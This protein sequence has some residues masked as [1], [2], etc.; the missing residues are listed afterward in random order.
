MLYRTITYLLRS[1]SWADAIEP[2]LTL[3]ANLE[4][5]SLCDMTIDLPQWQDRQYQYFYSVVFLFISFCSVTRH[6]SVVTSS[7]SSYRWGHLRG[8]G[9]REKHN[10]LIQGNSGYIWTNVQG[11]RD[12]F[13]MNGI[14]DKT[15]KRR[16][17]CDIFR[18]KGTCIALWV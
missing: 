10:L 3:C 17:K 11:I 18:I 9:E 14:F 2:M 13:T 1:F 6:R 16:R 4:R 5:G 15:L 7:S 12:I 8:F